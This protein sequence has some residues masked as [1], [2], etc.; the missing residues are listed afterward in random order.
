[1]LTDA[2]DKPLATLGDGAEVV[3]LAWIPGW[4]GAARYRVR[5]TDS[6]VE[7][8]LPVANLRRSFSPAGPP[9]SA[10]P[11]GSHPSGELGEPGQSV[12]RRRL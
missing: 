4:S 2:D 5:A 1:M 10:L 7:G 6:G 3:I 8:W 9:A 12:G 11:S